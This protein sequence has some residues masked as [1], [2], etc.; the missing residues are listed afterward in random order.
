MN[1]AM[2]QTGT[3]VILLLLSLG[4]RDASNTRRPKEAL[5]NRYKIFYRAKKIDA[6]Y[7]YF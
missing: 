1:L 6:S 3:A 4:M 2:T 7:K 5:D